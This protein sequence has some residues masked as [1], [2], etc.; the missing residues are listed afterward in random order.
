VLVHLIGLL[1]TSVGCL[2]LLPAPASSQSVGDPAKVRIQE[3]DRREL[4]LSDLGGDS[5][6]KNDPKQAQAIRDQV[7]EDFQRILKLHNEMVRTIATNGPLNY[8]FI[9]N[10]AG[11]IRKRATRLQSTLG[12]HKLEPNQNQ[13]QMRDLEAM[14]TKD[15]MIV[16]CTK[17]ESFVRN[18]IIDSPGTVNA[19][20]LDKARRDLDSVVE[21]SGAI[22]KV[23]D[24]QRKPW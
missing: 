5:K 8:E 16:L 11:E 6:N 21:L 18:P 24:R 14:R 4:Q 19:E 22:K 9:S 23:A 3:M 17:I 15:E 7:G 13:Q 2:I 20:L 1:V 10:A 12:L